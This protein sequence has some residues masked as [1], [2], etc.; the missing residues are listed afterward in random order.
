VRI[1]GTTVRGT[2]YGENC[3]NSG[4]GR[5]FFNSQLSFRVEGGELW[6]G[7]QVVVRVLG[8]VL[9]MVPVVQDRKNARRLEGRPLLTQLECQ[10]NPRNSAY[11]IGTLASVSEIR[12]RP[13]LLTR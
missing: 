13:K 9:G 2:Y 12:T 4:G 10:D 1:A 8:A 5:Q 7:N 3:E 6:R 11:G